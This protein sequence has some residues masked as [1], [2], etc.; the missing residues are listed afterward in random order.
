MT[1]FYALVARGKTVLAEYIATSGNFPTITR[2][3][4]AKI[5][6]DDQKMSYVCDAHVFHYVVE[7]GITYLC[8]A[9]D[10]NKRRIPFQFLEDIKGRFQTTYGDR[11]KQAIAF[12]MNEDFSRV[13]KSR[14]EFFNDNPAAD[15]FGRLRGQ[16]DEVRDIMVD[17]I[18]KVL[19]RGEKI[20]LLVDKTDQLNQS[21]FKFKKQAKQVKNVMWWKNVKIMCIIGFIIAFVIFFIVALICGFPT[22]SDC[23]SSSKGSSGGGSSG[24]SKSGSGSKAADDFAVEAGRALLGMLGAGGGDALAD[25]AADGAVAMDGAA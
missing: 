16:I 18:E 8:M 10:S 20:E 7:G 9:E 13:L 3:L 19:Q 14:M 23:S 25:G 2:L 24:G 15:N 22:F 5:T 6:P 17:N 1:I 11:A 21:A 12:A 4:L